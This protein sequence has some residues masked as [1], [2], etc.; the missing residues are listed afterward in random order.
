MILGIFYINRIFEQKQ[1]LKH[2]PVITV[3]LD[4]Y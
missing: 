2:E 1:F 3:S 4:T